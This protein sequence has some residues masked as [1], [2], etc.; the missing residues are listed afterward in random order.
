[1]ADVERGRRNIS[2][3][4]LQLIAQGLGMS[5]SRLFSRL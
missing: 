2:V 5:L 1:L 3:L 4:N